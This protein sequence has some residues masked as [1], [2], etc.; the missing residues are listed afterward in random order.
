MK[1]VS[2]VV[3]GVVLIV[4]LMGSF[5]FAQQDTKGCKDHPL[6]TRMPEY[7]IDSCEKK[8]FDAHAFI[9]PLTKKKVTVE[10]RLYRAYYYLKKEHKGQKS[11]LQV[12]RNH[13]NAIEKIGGV[14]LM[15]D[16]TGKD[17]T[18]MKVTKDDKE[19][20]AAIEQDNWGG[21]TYYLWIVE[22]TAMKQEI[23]A[24]AKLMADGISSTGHVAIYGIYFDFN[25]SDVKPESD[26]ALQEINKLL[27]GNLNLKLFI[28]GHTD[29]VGGVD[30]NM[31]LSQTRADAVV[32]VSTTKYKVNPQRFKAYGVG[33][34]A[35]VAPNKTEEGRAKN[36][37]VEL[38]EQ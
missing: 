21:S 10:G 38:V 31:K 6:F 2:T 3:F 36:R 32:K 23:T 34:L 9:D 25:K 18:W 1:R 13:T 7:Y 24:D 11:T 17:N 35:P 14:S 33:Q 5:A 29:N 27:S 28:V 30:Y 37:R 12:A 4:D 19:I 20:W 16:P 15:D 26:P 22:K 8:E